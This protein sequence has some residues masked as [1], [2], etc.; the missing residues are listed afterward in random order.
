MKL[1]RRSPLS[2]WLGIVTAAAVAVL[3]AVAIFAPLLWGEAA[4]LSDPGQI[5]QPPSREHPFGTD[6]GGRDVLLR[7]LVATQLSVSM[8][9]C[10]T[11][12]GVCG[13][14]LFGLVPAMLGRRSSRFIVSSINVA[15]AF[16]GLLLAIGLAVVLGQSALS[17]VIAIGAAMT[18]DYARLTYTLSSS[19]LGR[20]YV[21]AAR[22]LGVRP[23]TVMLR[24][25]LPNIRDPL[26]V[27]AT[28]SAGGSLVAFA[29]LSF[30]GLGVQAPDY[31]WGRLL[32]EGQSRIFVSPASA[33]VPGAAIVI[34]GLVFTLFGEF[35]AKSLPGVAAGRVPR[36]FVRPQHPTTG[37][38]LG[39]LAESMPRVLSV[40]DLN[41]SAPTESGWSH[42]VRGVSFDIAPGEIVGIV[43]ESGSGKSL[44]MMTIA[45]LT[46]QPLRAFADRLEFDGTELCR[47]GAVSSEA[48]ARR[49]S[50][51]L[52][53]HLSVV[54]QDPMSSLNPALRVG[55]QVAEVAQ[56]HENMGRSAA[57]ARAADRLRD[58]HIPDAER[59]AHQYPFEFSGGM[60][61]RAMIAMGLMGSPRLIIAD[62]PTTALD[63]TVQK[64]V[65]ELLKELNQKDGTAIA[66]ISHDIAVITSICTRV[67]V[68]YRGR[69]VEAIDVDELVA[70]RAK[71]PYTRA[72]LESV[73]T[74][75]GDRSAPLATI[76]EGRDFD[77]DSTELD[78]D[79]KGASAVIRA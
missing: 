30:L 40:R 29:S 18:P 49:H 74:M 28:I 38:A 46:E 58:V 17:A 36:R 23:S 39:T 70:G 19:V 42:P 76:P 73:P 25:V 2:T 32:G 7:T 56:L 59:R 67:L 13:G 63:V 10:A 66:L 57:R 50:R 75:D 68:M 35:L 9:L 77:D 47:P 44:T 62:E 1:R 52:G 26:I 27:R 22:V 64:G 15:V 3:L 48:I 11:L 45:G 71:H 78:S 55:S 20:D 69:I 51:L 34:A 37:D 24:H 72:L 31:D 33:L 53:T 61:Q 41:V 60:R 16:P 14:I 6:A 5:S 21:S 12:I 54:F 65:L 43:G 8:A 4:R 79:P